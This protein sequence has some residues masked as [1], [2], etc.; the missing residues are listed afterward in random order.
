[1]WV[2]VT[3]SG[4]RAGGGISP[5]GGPGGA[6]AGLPRGG[7]RQAEWVFEGSFREGLEEGRAECDRGQRGKCGDGVAT[8]SREHQ[9]PRWVDSRAQLGAD[10]GPGTCHPYSEPQAPF[11]SSGLMRWPRSCEGPK[12]HIWG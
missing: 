6:A 2:V 5:R 12:A 1:M 10:L 7:D 4:I 8:R 11:G 9:E 3:Q